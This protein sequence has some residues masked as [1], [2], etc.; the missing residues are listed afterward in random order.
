MRRPLLAI[1]VAIGASLLAVAPA[2][3]A[4]PGPNGKIAFQT[5][6]DGV[7]FEI[8][9]MNADGTNQTRLTNNAATDELPAWSPDGLKIA[10]D[11]NRDGNYEIY[12]MNADGTNQTRL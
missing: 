9:T 1:A 11:T 6:R 3:A 12:T 7:N 4:F 2:H 10:F 8:Y 5:S